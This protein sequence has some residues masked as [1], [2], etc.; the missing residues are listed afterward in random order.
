M[1]ADHK[2]VALKL[3]LEIYEF[4]TMSISP[5]AFVPKFQLVGQ[6]NS[7]QQNFQALAQAIQSGNLS[8]AQQ[9]YASLTQNAPAQT[10]N[11][12]SNGQTDPF[13]AIGSALQSGSISSAQTALQG[14][15]Q[16]MKAHHG[17]HHKAQEQEVSDD[18]AA[19]SSTAL[20]TVSPAKSPLVDVSA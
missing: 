3:R 12:T 5:V 13:A 8:S 17:H 6:Q 1:L 20:P 11:E 19:S 2:G 10:A 14:L 15:Q 9:A 4:S 7:M 18:A 16:T